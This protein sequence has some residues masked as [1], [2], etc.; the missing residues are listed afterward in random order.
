[1]PNR[2]RL[3]TGVSLALL[4]GGLVLLVRSAAGDSPNAA[5]SQRPP[6]AV[7]DA[8]TPRDVPVERPEQKKSAHDLSDIFTPS[9]AP[10]IT[11][12]LANQAD[13]G[14]FLGFD[15][16]RDPVGAMKPGTTFEDVYKALVAAKPKVMATQRA[17]LESR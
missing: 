11:E 16:Y 13:Q 10:P 6:D 12:A 4:A 2:R 9:K 7:A 15:L 5:P 17:L 3:V 1:M 8:Q 14:R